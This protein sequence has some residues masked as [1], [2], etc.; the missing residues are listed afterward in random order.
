MSASQVDLTNPRTKHR[1]EKKA[2]KLELITRL[3]M[4]GIP[5][6]WVMSATAEDLQVLWTIVKRDEKDKAALSSNST[7]EVLGSIF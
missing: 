2:D 3:I 5:R 4:H 7:A 1:I 6:D